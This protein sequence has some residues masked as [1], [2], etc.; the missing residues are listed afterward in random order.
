MPKK[1]KCPHCGKTIPNDVIA[2][3]LGQLSGKK[4]A[5]E[6]GPD[7]FRKLQAK[8]KTRSGGTGGGRPSNSDK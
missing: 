3:H 1:L 7:Y 2:A 4:L 8:R 5:S 6:R